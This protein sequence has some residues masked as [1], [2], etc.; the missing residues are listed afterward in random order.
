MNTQAILDTHNESPVHKKEVK[1]QATVKK[2][3]EEY[4][5]LKELH[6]TN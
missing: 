4:R 2:L 5:Q 1:G 6:E 3:K